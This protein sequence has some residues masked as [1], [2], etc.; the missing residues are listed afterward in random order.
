MYTLSTCIIPTIAVSIV[1]ASNAASKM[2]NEPS[3][4][5]LIGISL[6]LKWRLTRRYISL[7]LSQSS[8]HFKTILAV[9]R[10]LKPSQKSLAPRVWNNRDSYISPVCLISVCNTNIDI[11]GQTCLPTTFQMSSNGSAEGGCPPKA[12]KRF[13]IECGTVQKVYHLSS[14]VMIEK[15]RHYLRCERETLWSSWVGTA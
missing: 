6:E 15:S 10:L 13:F 1:T 7:A 14:E 8:R 5:T 9:N 2:A 4:A 12:V 11:Q 3:F